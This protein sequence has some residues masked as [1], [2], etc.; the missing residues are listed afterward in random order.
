MAYDYMKLSETDYISAIYSYCGGQ[1]TFATSLKNAIL[2]RGYGDYFV[3][4][5]FDHA[6]DND[7]TIKHPLNRQYVATVR[8]PNAVIS[9]LQNCFSD[10]EKAQ[11]AFDAAE[12][13][14]VVS[15]KTTESGTEGGTNA[16]T[17]HDSASGGST[18]T[19]TFSPINAAYE[20]TSDKTRTDS[21]ATNDRT[22]T[23]TDEK[24]TS[25]TSTREEYHGNGTPLETVSAAYMAL[26]PIDKF[27]NALEMILLTPE[28]YY[29]IMGEM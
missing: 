11:G 6:H 21:S 29:E 20:K 17:A 13:G 16:I 14:G 4:F 22:Q 8:A 10:I 9:L 1:T 24:N 23:T 12:Y 7:Q 5:P 2:Q 26:S 28:E 18:N 19:S 25:K 27:L 3:S 15:L